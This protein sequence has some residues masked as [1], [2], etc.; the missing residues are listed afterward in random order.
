M[1][2]NLLYVELIEHETCSD[3]STADD[4]SIFCFL[5]RK[6]YTNLNCVSHK[7]WY[8]KLLFTEIGVYLWLVLF[9][10]VNSDLIY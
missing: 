2:Q 9:T 3:I 8:I 10:S 6:M 4:D 1:N 5:H 7:C